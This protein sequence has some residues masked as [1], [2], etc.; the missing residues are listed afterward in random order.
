MRKGKNMSLVGQDNQVWVET[1]YGFYTIED[2]YLIYA[3]EQS[4]IDDDEC[5]VQVSDLTELSEEEY[6]HLSDL[7][8]DAFDFELNGQFL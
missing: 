4:D 5:L 8:S 2:G 7:L 3:Y 1:D 6:N